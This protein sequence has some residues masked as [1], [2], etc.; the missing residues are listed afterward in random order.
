MLRTLSALIAGRLGF[1]PV[2]HDWVERLPHLQGHFRRS[3]SENGL[4]VFFAALAF[5]LV[6]FILVM[7]MSRGAWLVDLL[8]SFYL[9]LMAAMVGLGVVMLWPLGRSY[10]FKN[11]ELSCVSWRGRVMWREELRG[12][13]YVTC[14]RGGGRTIMT[15]KWPERRRRIELFESLERALSHEH[16][17]KKN[18]TSR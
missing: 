11:G 6:P 12:L 10:V 4:R 9:A 18:G 1:S 15:L 5:G 17:L 16:P 7:E 3:A 14:S 13:E 2:G 8:D